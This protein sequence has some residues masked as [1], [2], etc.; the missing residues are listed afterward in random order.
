[1][2]LHFGLRVFKGKRGLNLTRENY[3]IVNNKNSFGICFSE[4]IYLDEEVKFYTKKWCEKQYK[5]C[6]M[7]F[8]LNMDYLSLLDHNEFRV[9]IENFVTQNSY[10]TE[11][12]D[13][14]PYDNKVGYYIMILDRY[15]QL[16][17]ET[18]KDIKKRIRQHWSVSKSFD[19]LLFP[20]GN[21]NSSIL[22]IYSFR[23]LD[24]TMRMKLTILL[25]MKINL[26]TNFRRSLYA[27]EWEAGRSMVVYFRQ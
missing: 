13:L 8:D 10:F 23:A 21:V 7:N 2:V 9:E 24:T 5:D 14:N 22:S 25:V 12:N 4:D 1:M 3:A 19:R 16:Y 11:V 15:K 27:I 18:T 17:V 26:L 20:M 6:L